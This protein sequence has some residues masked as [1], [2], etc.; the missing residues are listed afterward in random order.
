MV[1]IVQRFGAVVCVTLAVG[2]GAVTLK[3]IRGC[4]VRRPSKVL[5][6]RPLRIFVTERSPLPVLLAPIRLGHE[7]I[8]RADLFVVPSQFVPIAGS[9]LIRSFSRST[10]KLSN[11]QKE[12][13]K[14]EK[15]ER[16]EKNERRKKRKGKKNERGKE[17]SIRVKKLRCRNCEMKTS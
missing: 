8:R 5:R 6:L 1:G 2:G 10:L 16:K 17:K 12:K 7:P 9:R 3:V 13:K 14:K 15:K 11:C 4:A